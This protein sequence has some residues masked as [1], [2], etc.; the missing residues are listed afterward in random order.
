MNKQ[1][2]KDIPELVKADIISEETGLKIAKYYELKKQTAPNNLVVVLG[3]LGALLVGSGIVL[4]VA[5]NWDELSRFV[6]TILSFLP[7]VVAQLIC[8]YTLLKQ[9]DNRVWKEGSSIL[10]FF[11]IGVSISLISQIYQI[12]GSMSGFLLTW[13]I[14][15]LPLVYLLSSST[16]ALLCIAGFTWYACELGYFQRFPTIPLMYLAALILLVPYYINQ[17]KRNPA[18]N[19]I[20][21]L[22]WFIAISLIICLGSFTKQED[23]FFEWLFLLYCILFCIYY[24][25]GRSPYFTDKGITANPFLSTG[26]IGILIILLS[27]SF[28]FLWKDL[29]PSF[30]AAPLFS[31]PLLYI[32]I[33]GLA[34][35]GYLGYKNMQQSGKS[36][37]PAG[38]SF[39]LLLLLLTAF[40]NFPLTATFIIN[41]WIFFTAVYFIRKGS[42]ENHLGI[43]NFGLTILA[44]LALCRFFDDN[45]PF[46]WRGLFFVATGAGFFIANYLILKKR[47]QRL[48]I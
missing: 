27:W 10:L 38:Y 42:R 6:K 1:L 29:Q 19:T 26:I 28:E 22:H 5:H 3:V 2:L 44:S 12:S 32:I 33:T 23:A 24:F 21:L 34:A 25:I 36:F 4:I 37:D 48:K 20:Y 18:S 7:L 11:A 41:G 16:V 15:A 17:F 46:V 39:L 30:K 14:L 13:M 9:K 8:A 40:R 43:L 31:D 47:K 35:A 45:I